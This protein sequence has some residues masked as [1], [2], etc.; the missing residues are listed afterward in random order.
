MILLGWF[1]FVSLL[2]GYFTFIV[3]AVVLDMD[4]LTQVNSLLPQGKQ[5]PLIGRFRS[6]ELWRQYRLLFPQGKLLIRSRWL[7]AAGFACLFG[8]I[9]AFSWFH[10]SVRG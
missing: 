3:W 10:L 7:L 9:A 2:I 5:F 4:I 1:I 6:W 8:A